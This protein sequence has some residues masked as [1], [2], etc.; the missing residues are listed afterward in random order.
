MSTQP[1]TEQLVREVAQDLRE[2]YA[3]DEDDLRALGTELAAGAANAA[4]SAAFAQAFIA[5]HPATV[6]R[7]SR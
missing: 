3:L 7:L 6:E 2:R 5:D 4:Q 1:I